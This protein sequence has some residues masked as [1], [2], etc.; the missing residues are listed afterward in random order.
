MKNNIDE[1]LDEYERLFH[2]LPP[3]PIMASYSVIED[4]I[5]EAII[6]KR[7]LTAEETIEFYQDIPNDQG[8]ASPEEI[9]EG[10]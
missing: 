5:K 6:R 8:D 3:I 9:I 2:E 7:P 10:R 4:E 1:L